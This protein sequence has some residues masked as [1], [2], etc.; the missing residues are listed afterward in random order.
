MLNREVL[1]GAGVER[2]TGEEFCRGR[3][4]LG[5]PMASTGKLIKVDHDQG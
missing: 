5:K 3:L 1:E 4:H 2:E